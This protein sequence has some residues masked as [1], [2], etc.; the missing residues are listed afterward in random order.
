MFIAIKIITFLTPN[1][2]PDSNCQLGT[3]LDNPPPGRIRVNRLYNA[4]I[5]FLNFRILNCQS[6]MQLES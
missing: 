4:A 5:Q 6:V 2:L 1:N 3:I